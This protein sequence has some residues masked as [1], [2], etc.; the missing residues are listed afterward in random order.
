MR[1]QLKNNVLFHRY[2]DEAVILNMETESY[3]TLNETAL[4][5]WELLDGMTVEEACVVMAEEYDAPL[6]TLQQDVQAFVQ[7]LHEGKLV[8]L[9]ADPS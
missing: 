7:A 5:M 2:G 9:I 8:E 1:V 3:Y 6:E 4:R